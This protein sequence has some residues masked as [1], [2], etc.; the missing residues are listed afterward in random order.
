[1][2]TGANGS[3]VV[4]K[5]ASLTA[6]YFHGELLMETT[7]VVSCHILSWKRISLKSPE[8]RISWNVVG[9]IHRNSLHPVLTC[10]KI[11]GHGSRWW[12]YEPR[13]ANPP[14]VA[15]LMLNFRTWAGVW[16]VLLQSTRPS[17]SLLSAE[18]CW[19][20]SS[21][22]GGDARMHLMAHDVKDLTMFYRSIQTW[23]STSDSGST[24][25]VPLFS[26]QRC[27]GFNASICISS[28]LGLK[29]CFAEIMD[30]L[31]TNEQWEIS[32]QLLNVASIQ[33][34]IIIL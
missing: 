30:S 17:Q 9:K 16:V 29:T 34:I 31:F 24:K 18:D 20:V 15:G 5:C 4:L 21:A 12:G 32:P 27:S 33:I 10:K 8:Q 2:L 6:V 25:L 22:S 13:L 28:F 7:C 11:A 26:S 23:D 1:M 14:A 19:G 3:R